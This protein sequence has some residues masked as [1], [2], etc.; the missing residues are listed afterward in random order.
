MLRDALINL[1]WQLFFLLFLSSLLGEC[2]NHIINGYYSISV[3][4]NLMISSNYIEVVTTP[5]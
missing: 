4:C 1:R 2:C 3:S 5:Y